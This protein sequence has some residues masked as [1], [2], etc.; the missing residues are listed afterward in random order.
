[1]GCGPSANAVDMARQ[2]DLIDSLN[3]DNQKLSVEKNDLLLQKDG[4]VKKTGEQHN[5]LRY[6]VELLINMLAVEEKKMETLK[7]RYEALKWVLLSH[8][9]SEDTLANILNGSASPS[10]SLSADHLL[11]NLDLSSAVANMR[12]D[13]K[14]F[15]MEIM[16]AFADDEGKI[17]TALS[18]EDFIRQLYSVT[19]NITKKDVQLLA[20]RFFDGTAVSV[21]EFLGF[22]NTSDQVR[23]AKAA[24]ECVRMSLDLLQLDVGKEA[25]VRQSLDAEKKG[26]SMVS[27][28]THETKVLD[29]GVRK[30]V[31]NWGTVQKPL[32]KSFDDHRGKSDGVPT[33]VEDDFKDAIMKVCGSKSKTKIDGDPLTNDDVDLIAERFEIGGLVHT[34]HF[35]QYLKEV[36]SQDLSKDSPKKYNRPV[37]PLGTNPFRLSSEWS[38]LKSTANVKEPGLVSVDLSSL[39]KI[40]DHNK[41]NRVD[42]PIRK[43][44]SKARL[45]PPVKAETPK[46][47]PKTPPISTPAPAPAPSPAPAPIIPP[48]PVEDSE[49][50]ED[51]TEAE[52]I[53][54]KVQR[55]LAKMEESHGEA[56]DGSTDNLKLKR[57]EDENEDESD[58][59]DK[60]NVEKAAAIP[61]AK[62]L[63]GLVKG[64]NKSPAV[65]PRGNTTPGQAGTSGS[66]S[67][68]GTATAPAA[69]PGAGA[70]FMGLFKAKARGGAHPPGT[71]APV[72]AD[73]TKPVPVPATSTSAAGT[74]AA[75][76]QS[77]VAKG[78]ENA[79][80]AQG[81][82]KPKPSAVDSNTGAKATA[83]SMQ[84][85]TKGIDDAIKD[86]DPVPPASGGWGILRKRT[87][88]KDAS[89]TSSSQGGGGSGG[90]MMRFFNKNKGAAP[91]PEGTIDS[92]ASSKPG[93]A[94]VDAFSQAKNSGMDR[95]GDKTSNLSKEL[96]D[97]ADFKGTSDNLRGRMISGFDSEGK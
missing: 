84:I 90:G 63:P 26:M 97:K 66:V 87:V 14:Q 47:A 56:V 13:F 24:S 34:D 46:Q 53:R 95:G 30:L 31:N 70:W 57:P 92:A 80:L 78:F 73:Y 55:S 4:I 74:I 37:V 36:T 21:A 1:M 44:P 60:V 76:D 3:T 42:V 29:E 45:P 72:Q 28:Y 20:W 96:D 58:D 81:G 85:P 50:D 41:E 6:K 86:N 8:G 38:K 32:T 40:D 43:V 33:M 64:H 5:L 75:G 39:D 89:T 59:E 61:G 25:I 12:N 51:L 49:S 82:A 2:R 15:R 22:F 77:G 52:H 48:A 7:K 94:G 83:D 35:M 65:S 91:L 68:P 17:M 69:K 71:N 23:E 18:K 10:K 88:S 67:P 62:P 19:D 79:T 16:H 9:V 54:R 93:E 11:A 27:T